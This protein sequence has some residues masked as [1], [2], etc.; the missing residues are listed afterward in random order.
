MWIA[1]PKSPVAEKEG[2][3]KA[4]TFL[5]QFPLVGIINLRTEKDSEK[6]TMPQNETTL[7]SMTAFDP[8]K[9]LKNGNIIIWSTFVTEL[10]RE[11]NGSR[12]VH[13]MVR[14]G[15]EDIGR[16]QVE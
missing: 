6:L 16:R 10:S 8:S 14:K 3:S 7:V 4:T 11:Q 9:C 12:P 2:Y 1:L 5:L 15:H 13:K